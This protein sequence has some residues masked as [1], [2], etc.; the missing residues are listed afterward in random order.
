MGV[1]DLGVYV[2]SVDSTPP[3]RLQVQSF[4]SRSAWFRDVWNGGVNGQIGRVIEQVVD[5]FTVAR[6]T[7]A[8]RC[9]R[10][11]KT[12]GDFGG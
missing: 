12:L 3:T 9:E 1:E 11:L 8:A 6:R 7:G 10:I 4:G 5:C 2:Q